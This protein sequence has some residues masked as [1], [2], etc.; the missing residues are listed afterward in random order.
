MLTRIIT[1]LVG[2][3]VF[4]GAFIANEVVFSLAVAVVSAIMVYETVNA[5]KVGKVITIISVFACILLQVPAIFIEGISPLSGNYLAFALV[6]MVLKYLIMS[7]IKFGKK[8]VTDVY[9]AM[10]STLYIAL[11]MYFVILLRGYG[12]YAV[13]P[14]FIY[15]WL[16]D[17]GAYFTGCFMGK[18]K[19]AP[20]LSPKKT[21]EGFFG[22]IVTAVIG[23]LVYVIILDK[24]FAINIPN[25]WILIAASPIGAGLSALGDLAASALKRQCGVKDFGR[26]FPGHGGMMDRFDSVV[27]VAPFVYLVFWIIEMI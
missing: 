26:I 5:L 10:F 7:V 6:V 4:F 3:V 16:T 14:I 27:F 1:A 2:L 23:A 12:R 21:I 11:F 22:G 8:D 19:L 9:S 18:H 13:M 25:Y 15:S 20:N 17:T 24:F